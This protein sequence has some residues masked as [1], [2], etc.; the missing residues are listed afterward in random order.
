MAF[1]SF[2]SAQLTEPLVLQLM[3]IIQRD[4]A[5]SLA[6]VDVNPTLG[7]P[8]FLEYNVTV[9]EP[10]QWP[11]LMVAAKTDTFIRPDT[12]NGR[13][14]RFNID[15]T[16]ADANQDRNLVAMRIWRYILAIDRIVASLGAEVNA[17]N[18]PN[19]SDFYTPL[20]VKISFPQSPL[21]SAINIATTNGMAAGTVLA[22]YPTSISY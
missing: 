19:F 20:P 21:Q 7:L 13:A 15:M 1:K 22:C 10:A 3:A 4:I 16:V 5:A 12:V 8:T 11:T 2:F 18:T 9:Y 6:T 17:N 14:Q